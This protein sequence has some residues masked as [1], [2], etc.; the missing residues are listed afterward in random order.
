MIESRTA[1]YEADCA[2]KKTETNSQN[3]QTRRRTCL[4]ALAYPTENC[5]TPLIASADETFLGF[6]FMKNQLDQQ[7]KQSVLFSVQFL[8]LSRINWPLK[9]VPTNRI[10]ATARI[11]PFGCSAR[12]REMRENA[13]FQSLNFKVRPL[14]DRRE[15]PLKGVAESGTTS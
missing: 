9:L 12:T 5:K 4:L 6:K 15:R 7:S 3:R 13:E 2:P 14:R 11:W 8:F 10:R 1:R